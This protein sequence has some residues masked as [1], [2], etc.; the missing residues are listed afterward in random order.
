MY[1]DRFEIEKERQLQNRVM[2]GCAVAIIML[3]VLLIA[4]AGCSSRKAVTATEIANDVSVADTAA[5][6]IDATLSTTTT[7]DTTKTVGKHESTDV[8]EFVEGGGRVNIDSAGNVTIEGVKI[9]NSNRKS[10]NEQRKGIT[11]SKDSTDTHAEQLNGV[12]IRDNSQIKAKE[13]SKQAT[14]WYDTLFV[15]LG[16]GVCIALLMWVLFLYLKRKK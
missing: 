14:K 11:Q 12:R 16:Q 9:I 13:T 7:V 15:R 6:T 4:C 3:L 1:K 10:R 8:V 5:L 2:G